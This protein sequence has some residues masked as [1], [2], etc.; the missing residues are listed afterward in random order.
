MSHSNPQLEKL[1]EAEMMEEAI[2]VHSGD[3]FD[4]VKEVAIGGNSPQD[5]PAH[6]FR[7]P[8]FLGTYLGFIF[9]YAAG[10]LAYTMIANVLYVID[11]DI[12]PS[13]QII[14]VLLVFTVC[15]TVT[16]TIFGRLS[17]I[18]GRRW[19]Y[20]GGNLLAIIGFIVSSQAKSVNAVIGG[21]V[22][23]G[24]GCGVQITGCV[25]SGELIPNAY[26]MTSYGIIASVLGPFEAICP[27]IARLL[28]DNTGPGWRWVYYLLIIFSGLSMLL[29]IF[30]YHPP[31]FEHLHSRASRVEALK[32]LDY[33]G[34][35]LYAGGIVCIL[36]AI[37]WGGQAYA[38]KSS[39]VIATFVIGGLALVSF[40][41]Y[42]VYGRA[43][44]PLT[45]T[46]LFKSRNY[47]ALATVASFAG[48]NFF[49]MNIV[50]P[51][52]LS[53]AGWKSSAITGGD[54]LGN[55]IGAFMTMYCPKIKW[56]LVFATSVLAAFS[57]ALTATTSNSLTENVVFA[58][59]QSTAIGWAETIC[60]AGGPLMLD[61]KD[62]GVATGFQFSIRTLLASLADTIYVTILENKLSSNLP[63]YV[64]KAALAAGLPAKDLPDL[65]VAIGSGNA[66]AV[67]AVPDMTTKI[68]LAVEGVE[69]LAYEKS[70]RTVYLTGVAFG[71]VA[72]IAAACVDSNR[73]DASLTHEVGRKLQKPT[74]K[75]KGDEGFDG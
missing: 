30:F 47:L 74:L 58:L 24:I 2:P 45:P 43:R 32:G 53:I 70:F 16:F 65:F 8:R 64:T 3:S 68:L 40:G 27:A 14:W 5:L 12:G 75:S 50:Y 61:V 41:L 29:M 36:L 48:M 11:A 52:M 62:I 55:V 66:T 73:L 72:V 15:Q 67:T 31:K 69:I 26:R 38:W 33:L 49:A 25:I 42:E 28:C 39:H 37:S 63:H 59:I 13:P 56:Q 35:V 34:L 6:Y 20:I 7:S 17:D 57:G 54:I 18:F 4:S 46:Y 9:S 71:L 1:G 23:S 22:L 19:Y 21:S 44:F 10:F 60:L 51:E